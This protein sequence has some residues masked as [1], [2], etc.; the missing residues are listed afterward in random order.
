MQTSPVVNKMVCQSHRQ[1]CFNKAYGRNPLL[2]SGNPLNIRRR[3]KPWNILKKV[4][5]SAHLV[6]ANKLILGISAP[7][8]NAESIAAKVGIA[9][10]YNLNGVALWRLGL[11]N[12]G[13]WQTL[14]DSLIAKR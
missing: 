9:K 1:R 4:G 11:I 12:D 5:A 6:P 10:R 13:M 3:R 2:A 14:R 7:S 8:E